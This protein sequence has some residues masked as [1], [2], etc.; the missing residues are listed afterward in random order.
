[1]FSNEKPHYLAAILCP[2]DL[3]PYAR[4]AIAYAAALAR[5]AR[6]SVTL[7]YVS[8]L[9]L[10]A[11]ADELP[12]WMPAEG[13]SR[14]TRLAEELQKLA[15]PL[16]ASGVATDLHFREGAVGE[17]IVRAASDLG[18]DLIAMGT[19]GRRGLQKVLGSHAQHV[20]RFAR[21]PVLTVSRPLAG[22][23]DGPAQIR[24]ILC[25]A[26][27]AEQSA[28]TIAYAAR[29]AAEAGTQL[30][31]VQV[32]EPGVRAPR[33]PFPAEGL[34][35]DVEHHVV[36]GEDPYAEIVKAAQRDGADLIVVGR[37]DRAPGVFG[38]FGST[39]GRLMQAAPCA[40]LAVPARPA[41]PV[42]AAR[43]SA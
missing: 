21:C 32:H 4:H 9:P 12:E 31:L 16:R 28:A 40:V 33:L 25:A 13:M 19:H 24:R 6:A 14:G 42:P 39:C 7:M 23:E 29:L 43:L 35:F 5:P 41:L 2:T 22:G 3:G 36:P 17:E 27:G 1:M 10:P 11:V 18:A 34:P 20:L 37:H 8:P 38:F 15:A 26:S 30:S